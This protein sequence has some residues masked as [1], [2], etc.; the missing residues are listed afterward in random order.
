M[1]IFLISALL[2]S[3]AS[4]AAD[5]RTEFFGITKDG[6]RIVKFS[7]KFPQPKMTYGWFF[8]SD[9]DSRFRYCWKRSGTD[10]DYFQCAPQ[11]DDEPVVSYKS[12][13]YY[14][15]KYGDFRSKESRKLYSGAMEYFKKVMDFGYSGSYDGLVEYYRCYKGCDN[16]L[17]LFVFEFSFYK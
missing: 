5:D 2:F 6:H 10:A 11:F 13:Q 1:R 16:V 12:G 3:G 7:D 17:P 8:R 14:R 15:E 4:L 9:A